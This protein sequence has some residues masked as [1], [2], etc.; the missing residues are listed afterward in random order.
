MREFGRQGVGG[1][2]RNGRSRPCQQ[3][4]TPILTNPEAVFRR[5]GTLAHQ[6]RWL[7]NLHPAARVWRS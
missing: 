6:D 7:R 5:F 1:S 3:G 4:Q 2:A